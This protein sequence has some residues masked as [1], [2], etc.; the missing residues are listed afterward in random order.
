MSNFKSTYSFQARAELA[1]NFRLQYP[2]YI[3]I[4]LENQGNMPTI[5]RP[6]QLINKDWTMYQVGVA[7]KRLIDSHD[8]MV[9]YINDQ[10]I[11]DLNV[12]LED[13]YNEYKDADGLLYIHCA[14]IKSCSCF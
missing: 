6:K 13:I 10:L 4:I 7:I 11:S 3:P 9:M 14:G 12:T 1:H 8:N 5:T 2:N